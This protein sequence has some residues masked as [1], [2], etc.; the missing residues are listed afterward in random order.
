[1]DFF[2]ISLVVSWPIYSPKIDSFSCSVC[3]MN[4][5]D[6][7][8]LVQLMVLCSQYLA[9]LLAEHQKLGP[10]TQVLPICSKLL[11]QGEIF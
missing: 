3:L 1:M 5:D 10:F 11:S 9:E 6:D 8:I 4:D 2:A 7:V